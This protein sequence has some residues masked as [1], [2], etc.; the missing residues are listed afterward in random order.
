M[1]SYLL[2]YFNETEGFYE[3]TLL[4]G[5]S[6]QM[7]FHNFVLHFLCISNNVLLLER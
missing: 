5:I 3:L 2:I 6:I 7:Y 1:L 4:G